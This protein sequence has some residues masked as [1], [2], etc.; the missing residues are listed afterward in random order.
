MTMKSIRDFIDQVETPT[1][2]PTITQWDKLLGGAGYYPVQLSHMSNWQEIIVWCDETVGEDH[3]TWTGNR[4]W[5][6]T[7]EVATLF[8]LRWA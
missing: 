6:E 2:L 8:V 1:Q 4:M 7:S 5:F 3:Y